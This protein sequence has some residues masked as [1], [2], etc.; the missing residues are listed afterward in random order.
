[1]NV[2]EEI[3]KYK[4]SNNVTI[5]QPNRWDSILKSRIENGFSKGLS[6]KFIKSIFQS[7][8]NES[9]EHQAQIMNE[10]KLKQ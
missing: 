10:E 9:I 1:M 8:H 5:Y 4:K 3:A 6:E 7:I 2:V